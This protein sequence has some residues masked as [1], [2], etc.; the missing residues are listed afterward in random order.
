MTKRRLIRVATQ[1]YLHA[2]EHAFR[3][4]KQKKRDFRQLWVSR[5]SQAVK[6]QGLSYSVFIKKLKDAHI[7][8][9]RKVLAFLVVEKPEAFT[10][11]VDKVK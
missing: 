2:G 1:A 10:A 9:D 3:G 5:I 4:R 7:A 8:L 6:L 11:V